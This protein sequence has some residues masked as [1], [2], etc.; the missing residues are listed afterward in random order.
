MTD[1]LGKSLSN[2]SVI[3]EMLPGARLHR[4]ALKF[5]RKEK[6]ASAPRHDFQYFT[7]ASLARCGRR[8]GATHA[9]ITHH[10]HKH[11]H[12]HTHVHTSYEHYMCILHLRGNTWVGE[13]W[14][15]G[16]RRYLLVELDTGDGKPV[17]GGVG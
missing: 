3:S 14:E 12:A 1:S 17:N 5:L 9:H 13:Q 10:K 6:D 7:I 2:A 16:V 8:M 15:M 4:M 11:K